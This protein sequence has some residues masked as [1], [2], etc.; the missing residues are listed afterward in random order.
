MPDLLPREVLESGVTGEVAGGDDLKS[1]VEEFERRAIERAMESCNG[2][3]SRAA[4]M[5]GM[6]RKGLKGKIARYGRLRGN[7]A[8][9]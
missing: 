9:D 6:S 8:G 5:L 3:K 2:N 1:R 7:P 4:A